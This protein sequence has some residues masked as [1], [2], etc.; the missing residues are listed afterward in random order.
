MHSVKFAQKMGKKI[1]VLS[2]RI[3]ES[4]GTNELLE[5]SL[6]QPIYNIDT[7]VAGYTD[8][9]QDTKI[10]DEFLLYCDINPTYDEAL[11][12]YP[13]KVFEAELNGTIEIKNGKVFRV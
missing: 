3:G 10:K 5:N 2:H 11:R 1:Y 12:R 9:Y 7:F 8:T 4:Q 6:A 13:T